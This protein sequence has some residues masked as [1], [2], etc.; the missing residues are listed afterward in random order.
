ME[1]AGHKKDLGPTLYPSHPSLTYVESDVEDTFVHTYVIRSTSVV[2]DS[3]YIFSGLCLVEDEDEYEY[4]LKHVIDNQCMNLLCFF[5]CTTSYSF[6]L[7]L[8]KAPLPPSSPLC[9]VV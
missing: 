4:L 9:I 3:I 7:N 2:C 1:S 8:Y 5:L 6:Y